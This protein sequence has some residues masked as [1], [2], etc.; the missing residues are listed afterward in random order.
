MALTICVNSCPLECHPENLM[1]PCLGSSD[2]V[3]MRLVLQPPL[4]GIDYRQ[5]LGMRHLLKGSNFFKVAFT[6]R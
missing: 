6:D 2:M 5:I 3:S 4:R 1:F